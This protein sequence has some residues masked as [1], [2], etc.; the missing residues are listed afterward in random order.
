[1]SASCILQQ[2]MQYFSY[3]ITMAF[4]LVIPIEQ[5]GQIERIR[6]ILISGFMI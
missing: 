4:P 6:I 5:R 2:L 3:S 1:M